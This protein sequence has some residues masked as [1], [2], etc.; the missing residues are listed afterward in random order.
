MILNGLGGL[1]VDL[2]TGNAKQESVAGP[3]GV[4]QLTGEAAR[5]GWYSLVWFVALLSLNLAVL[6][7]MPIPA[8]DGG[9]F[10]FM[11]IELVTRRRVS[12]RYE[13]YAHA[14]GLMVLL[15]LMA[16]ITVLD[17]SRIIQGK[18]LLP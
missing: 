13:S 4:A 6:N 5:A 3:L 12:P 18:S 7:I 15:G 9:R 17:V 2:V 14:V 11:L 10:F 8:L 16:L 1:V